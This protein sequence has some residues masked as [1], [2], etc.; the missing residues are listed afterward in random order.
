MRVKYL[1]EVTHASLPEG[2]SG[3]ELGIEFVYKIGNDD[4]KTGAKICLV[5]LA[6]STVAWQVEKQPVA[7]AAV[8]G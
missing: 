4:P 3:Y 1:G 2:A 8:S 7:T 6:G 5:N